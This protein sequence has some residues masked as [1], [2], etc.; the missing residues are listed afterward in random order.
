MEINED[1]NTEKNEAPLLDLEIQLSKREIL[2]CLKVTSKKNKSRNI[3]QS[4]IL[5]IVFA[6]S[7]TSYFMDN[8]KYTQ[9]LWIALAS[10]IVFAIMWLVPRWHD[11]F[12]A[13]QIAFEQPVVKLRLYEDTIDFSGNKAKFPLRSCIPTLYGDLL[14][15]EVGRE[16]VGIPR[17]AAGEE[18]FAILLKKFGLK[19]EK[20]GL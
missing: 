2:N 12:T 3:I 8:M 10:M 20:R 18:E 4:V 19:G 7:I 15:L 6:V 17:R 9:S 13:S 11:R 5:V 1:K 14:V 16:I